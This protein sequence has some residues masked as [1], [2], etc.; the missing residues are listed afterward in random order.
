M[1]NLFLFTAFTAECGPMS[2]GESATRYSGQTPDS[3]GYDE[4]IHHSRSRFELGHSRLPSRTHLSEIS[5]LVLWGKQFFVTCMLFIKKHL[6]LF[7]A[8]LLSNKRSA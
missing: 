1:L 6:F 4:R 2:Y 5:S 7:Y 8:E 3:G